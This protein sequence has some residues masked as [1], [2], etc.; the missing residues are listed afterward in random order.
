M[1]RRIPSPILPLVLVGLLSPLACTWALGSGEDPPPMHRNL[2]RSVD[3]QTGVVQGNL[4]RVRDAGTW[5][6]DQGS[7]MG[8]PVAVT[9][10]FEAMNKEAR[11]LSQAND[12]AQAAA[13]A[14]RLAATCGG[15]HVE[16]GGGP[17]F[18]VGSEAPGGVSQE[19]HMIRHLWATDRMWEG[20][21]GPSDEAWLAGAEALAVT[22]PGMVDAIRATIPPDAIEGFL[23]GV[24]DAARIALEAEGLDERARA[25]GDAVRAC[26]QCHTA[27]GLPIRP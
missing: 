25:Y 24:G 22:D 6:L 3:I 9:G 5:L 7:Y 4:Q 15:C 14:G 10:D 23:A 19:A 18:V 12:L 26:T 8:G 1:A 27:I 21:V 2:S 16:T 11:V 20:L 17:R 13:A